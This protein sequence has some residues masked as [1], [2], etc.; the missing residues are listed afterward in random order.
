MFGRPIGALGP[1]RNRIKSDLDQIWTNLEGTSTLSQEAARLHVHTNTLKDVLVAD[2][3]ARYQRW[4][5]GS[6]VR[7]AQ[8][9]AKQRAR[10]GP[11]KK[12]EFRDLR[13]ETSLQE[14]YDA[15]VKGPYPIKL[16]R[17]WD[18]FPPAEQAALLRKVEYWVS[19]HVAHWMT[20]LE[21]T[22]D[23]ER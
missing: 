8:L 18:D 10:R 14:H 5:G 22:A 6:H 9:R 1:G 20:V 4:V 21:P 2:N 13:R 7:A 11:V 16:I 17:R 15:Y 3:P 19:H 23:L 12:G